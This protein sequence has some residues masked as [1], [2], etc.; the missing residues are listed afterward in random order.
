MQRFMDLPTHDELIAS[1]DA[2]RERHGNMAPTRFGSEATGD[3]NLLNELRHKG[4]S[5]S[6]AVLHR[7]ADYI[8]RKDREAGHGADCTGSA[9]L[10]S[11]GS[12]SDIS[13][14]VTA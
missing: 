11:S 1:I 10:S 3:P 8:A 13:Q 14:Q 4:R 12:S 2:F 6:L 5:P 9:R 7:V